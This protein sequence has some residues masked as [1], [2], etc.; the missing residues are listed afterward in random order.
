MDKPK[1]EGDV[2]D[3]ISE[4]SLPNAKPALDF[5]DFLY[6]SFF[7]FTDFLSD[8]Y[9]FSRCTFNSACLSFVLLS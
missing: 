5:I 3:V 4:K 8:L 9:S 1:R 2:F 6:F 7:H